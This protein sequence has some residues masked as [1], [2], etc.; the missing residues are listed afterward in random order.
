MFVRD[1]KLNSPTEVNPRLDQIMFEAKCYKKYKCNEIDIGL[2]NLKMAGDIIDK[3]IKN[4]GN[5]V[6]SRSLA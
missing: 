2:I 3:D 4:N 6:F 1:L 5:L